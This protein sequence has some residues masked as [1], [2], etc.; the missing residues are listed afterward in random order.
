M[1]STNRIAIQNGLNPYYPPQP[2]YSPKCGINE[3]YQ[4]LPSS[5][6]HSPTAWETTAASPSTIKHL[7]T[8][9]PNWYPYQTI[10][11]PMGT[12]YEHDYSQFHETGVGVG[13]RIG[14][15]YKVYPFTNRNARETHLYA[16]ALLPYMDTRE[17][18]RYPVIHDASLNSS[19]QYEPKA[20]TP[21]YR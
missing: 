21:D 14:Y 1:T 6:P 8:G 16:D 19:L 11:R 17:W 12:M 10:T 18:E 13:K 9:I 15:Q 2:D 4:T 3:I 7:Y 5:S 20:Y